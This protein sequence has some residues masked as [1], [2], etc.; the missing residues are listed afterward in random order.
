MAGIAV[1]SSVCTEQMGRNRVIFIKFPVKGHERHSNKG[2]R[3]TKASKIC[4]CLFIAISR[5]ALALAN[6][7]TK[8]KT[9][10]Y[11]PKELNFQ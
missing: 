4:T 11:L 6:Q 7:V 10:M 5:C 8:E 2:G 1:L 3:Q 9:N